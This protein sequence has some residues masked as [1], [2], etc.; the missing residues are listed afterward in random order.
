MAVAAWLEDAFEASTLTD[1]ARDY[2]MGRGATP[3]VIEAWGLTVFDCPLTP[4]PN[5]SL[6]EHHGQFFERYEGKIVYPL[7]SPRG[8]LLGFES[9][10]LDRKDYDQFLLPESRWNPVWI[11]MP[12]GM[13]PIWR[14][15]DV[16]VVEGGF[17]VF[18]LLHVAGD[19]AV[20]GTSTAHLSWKH[21]E[22]LRRWAQGRVHMTYDMD[23][24]GRKGAREAMKNLD[25]R[26]VQCS[27]VRYGNAGD[28]PGSIWDRG[29]AAGLREAFPH[30]Q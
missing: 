6:H 30:F 14:G 10:S 15:R 22:F 13:D 8:T 20:L 19:R 4:C 1:E 3:E 23:D 26:G 7:R 17:D 16:I 25:R 27:E 2:L 24:A 5:G 28:D 9:R 21:V 11:G 18:A 29:G 12:Q